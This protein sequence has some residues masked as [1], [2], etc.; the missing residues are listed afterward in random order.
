MTGESGTGPAGSL[1]L[2]ARQVGRRRSD[3]VAL[4]VCL[5]VTVLGAVLV[6]RADGPDTLDRDDWSGSALGVFRSTDPAEVE[7]FEQ[8]LG[9]PV[10][11]I[12][13]FSARANWYDISAPDYLLDAWRGKGYTLVLGVAMLPTDVPGV[14]I[15]EGATGAYDDWYRTL[16]EHLVAGGFPDAV[17]RIGWEFNSDDWPWATADA[18]AWATYFRRIVDALRSVPGQRLRIDWNVNN[19][20]NSYDAVRYWP[21]DAYVDYVGVDVYDLWDGDDAGTEH[22]DC[23]GACLEQGAR[24]A[25][26]TRIFGGSRG[27][28]FWSEF[29]AERDKQL[30]LPEWGAWSRVDHRGGGDNPYFIDRMA[31]FISDPGNRVGYHGYFEHAG[32]LGTHRLMTDLPDAGQRYRAAFSASG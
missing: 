30:S 24:E 8:W 32:A 11:V 26:G 27:L 9:R 31:A 16:A 19:G 12:V 1:G 23:T 10:D 4:T 17:L 18:Q 13:D 22:R 6:V 25:W 21:G 7:A 3:L 15:L 28:R 20:S 29:A 14:S 2:G 5:V